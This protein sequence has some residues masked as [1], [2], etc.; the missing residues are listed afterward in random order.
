MKPHEYILKGSRMLKY[1]AWHQ[2]IA[3]WNSSPDPA[4]PVDSPA[5]VDPVSGATAQDLL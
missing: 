3:F 5:P 4:D 2:H 1:Y